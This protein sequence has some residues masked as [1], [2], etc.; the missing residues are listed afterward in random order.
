MS[1][2]PTLI[3]D[4]AVVGGA[5]VLIS[6]LLSQCV[7]REPALADLLAAQAA[8]LDS[9]VR[10]PQRYLEDYS[11]DRFIDF[12]REGFT[13]PMLREVWG[14]RGHSRSRS[15]DNTI[16]RLRAKI[17]AAPARPA[18]VL[19]VHGVGYRFEP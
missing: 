6:G 3:R 4:G 5:M 15:A 12:R 10:S 16:L 7:D 17:E 13:H 2:I 1:E 11:S 18:H 19:T 9:D 8:D 14:Y